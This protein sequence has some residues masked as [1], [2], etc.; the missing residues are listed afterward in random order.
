VS[1]D[2]VLRFIGGI[3]AGVTTYHMAN[4][5]LN[6]AEPQA[7]AALLAFSIA[8]L[9]F[10]VGFTIT[11]YVTIVPFFWFR[12]R[13]MHASAT[14]YVV[15][16]IGLVIGLFCGNLLHAPLSSL[17][18]DLGNWLPIAASAL[19][20]YFGVITM[21]QHKR[22]LLELFGGTRES[23]RGRVL[24]GGGDRVLVDTSAI[25]DGRIADVAQ[26]GFLFCTLVVPRF[27]LGELQQVADS[28]DANK[29]AR[30][31]RG[32]EILEQLQ[33]NSL[34]PVEIVDLEVDGAMDVDSKLVRLARS[35]DWSLLTN[36]Y[37]LNRVAALQGITVLNINDLANALKAT[38]I[39]GDVI[40]LRIIHPGKDAGQGVGYLADGTMVVVEAASRLVGDESDIIVTRAIQTAAGRII[41]GRLKDQPNGH[42]SP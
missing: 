10:A 15:G 2:L 26:T 8:S 24:T 37:N 31:R 25:I 38:C 34:A 9:A 3:L 7:R 17:P 42:S 16:G 41:F 1:I 36:D 30:G 22:G 40:R 21:V 20:A 32:L 6:L 28:A 33:K 19:F 14:D 11:P 4:A 5:S 35:R 12:E 23:V 39:P 27:V 13:V 29:R 18:G